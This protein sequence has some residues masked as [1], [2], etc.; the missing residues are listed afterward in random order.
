MIK[1]RPKNL[2][3]LKIRLPVTGLV[4]IL[5]RLSGV[6]LF[7]L[8]PGILWAFELSLASEYQFQALFSVSD[9][10][11]ILKLIL[12]FLL[13]GFFHHLFAGVRHLFLDIHWGISLTHSRLTAKFIMIFSLF[14]TFL[15][16]FFLW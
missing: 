16:G 9:Y 2:N 8:V 7:L 1:Q 3:L 10:T 14:I 15:L 13:W 6:L 12:L 4:S 11:P 5:H